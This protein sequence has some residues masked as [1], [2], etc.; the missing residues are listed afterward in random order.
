[1][2]KSPELFVIDKLEFLAFTFPLFSITNPPSPLL[3]ML[4]V[5]NSFSA[6]VNLFVTVPAMLNWFPSF[7]NVASPPL[8]NV[9]PIVKSPALFVTVAVLLLVTFPEIFNP[10]TPVFNIARLFEEMLPLSLMFNPALPWFVYVASSPVLTEPVTFKPPRPCSVL[11]NSAL[12]VVLNSPEIFNAPVLSS[13]ESP[14]S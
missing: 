10:P 3:I 4:I 1:M 13:L 9:P 11:R 12:P 7:V 2:T 14:M 8:T 6:S 5:P